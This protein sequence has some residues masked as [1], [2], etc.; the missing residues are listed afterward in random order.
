MLVRCT[1]TIK[2]FTILKYYK[3]FILIFGMYPQFYSLGLR[4]VKNIVFSKL[5]KLFKILNF[6]Q[7]A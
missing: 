4:Q 1:D 3:I 7:V 2:I 5:I 6:L